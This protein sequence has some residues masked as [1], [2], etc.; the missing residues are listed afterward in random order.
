MWYWSQFLEQEAFWINEER[1]KNEPDIGIF[2]HITRAETVSE[3]NVLISIGSSRLI[4]LTG[5]NF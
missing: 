3:Y 2:V 4:F 5:L 1:F